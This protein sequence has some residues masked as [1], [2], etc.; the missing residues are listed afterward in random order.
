M[1]LLYDYKNLILWKWSVAPDKKILFKK[2]SSIFN[3]CSI[4]FDSFKQNIHHVTSMSVFVIN[5]LQKSY[6]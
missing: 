6:I 2:I 1:V 3:F 4:Y 5:T